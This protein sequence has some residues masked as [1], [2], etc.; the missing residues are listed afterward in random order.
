[1]L[2]IYFE[3]FIT[4][5]H[6]KLASTVLIYASRALGPCMKKSQITN[7]P[8]KGM[9]TLLVGYRHHYEGFISKMYKVPKYGP[10]MEN[11]VLG[12]K[13]SSSMDNGLSIMHQ[14][15]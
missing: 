2:R 14:D 5:W 10:M 6:L 13:I 15:T 8:R 7:G 12:S 3:A 1:M 4:I 11:E 9:F